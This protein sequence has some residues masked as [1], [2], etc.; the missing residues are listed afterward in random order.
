MSGTAFGTIVLHISPEAA[1]GGPLGL[2]RDGDM[3]SLDVAHGVISLVVDEAELARRRAAWQAPP[4]VGVERGYARLYFEQV[5]Q[6][7][8]G[9]DF[10][11]LRKHPRR[12]GVLSAV[13]PRA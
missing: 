3:I 9:C 4:H 11:F 8:D 2:V 10:D 5:L 6:A 12:R 7:E 1:E 13:R